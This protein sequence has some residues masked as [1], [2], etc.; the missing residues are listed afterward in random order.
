MERKDI[1]KAH[2]RPVTLIGAGLMVGDKTREFTREVRN[3]KGINLVY[4]RPGH[5][6]QTA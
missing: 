6:G 3:K 1:V 4:V 5:K 2:G